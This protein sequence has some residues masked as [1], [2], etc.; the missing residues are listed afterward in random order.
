GTNSTWDGPTYFYEYDYL[1]DSCQQINGPT[2][3]TVSGHPY[4]KRLLSLPNGS[5]LMNLNNTQP[6]IYSPDG[7]PLAMGK[8]TILSITTNGDDSFHLTGQGLNG[9]S[10]GA[11]Y[12]DDAQMNANYPLVRMTNIASGLVYYAR[13]FNWT[14]TSVLTNKTTTTE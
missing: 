14:S 8:P 9:L 4:A 11:A 10:V 5:V 6:Y 1:T 7:T 3:L 12:G 2:G 13:T